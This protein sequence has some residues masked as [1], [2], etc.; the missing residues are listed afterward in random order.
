MRRISAAILFG[1]LIGGPGV[2]AYAQNNLNSAHLRRAVSILDSTKEQDGLVGAVRRVRTES[3]KLELK[4]GRSVEGPLELVELTTYGI[5]GN[6]IE[7]TSY[8]IN[9]SMLGKE[10][11]KYD[12]K[13][14]I[15]ETTLRDERGTILS[16]EA[17]DYEFD[18]IGNWTKMTTSLIVFQ[19]GK[20]NH[21]PIEV[22]YRTL[23]YYFD[24]S[25]AKIIDAPTQA[26]AKLN[27]DLPTSSSASLMDTVKSNGDPAIS[28]RPG[29]VSLAVVE[30]PP[31]LVKK[32]KP[33]EPQP[34]TTPAVSTE[35][36]PVTSKV[37]EVTTESKP[38]GKSPSAF[39]FYRVGRER[40]DAG[41]L[42]AAV[43]AYL[44]SVKI[45]PASAEVHLSL[46]LTYMRLEKDKEALKSF[47]EAVKLNPDLAEA[48]YGLG[49]ASFRLSRFRDASDAFKKAT[50][51]EP[52][53]AKAHYGLALTYQEL[54]EQSLLVQELRTL[55]TLDRNLAKKLTQAFPQMTSCRFS[56]C[57]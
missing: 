38:P 49:I 26:A 9:G 42:K 27:T 48:Q 13:G 25:V 1:T 41:D 31:A 3:A 19:N 56:Q 55:E 40:F 47:K 44:E 52:N 23:T 15:I 12:E 46:G 8:P 45:E 10:E 29:L 5:K 39:E 34:A 7:N 35:N 17:Y 54:G 22:T 57:R 28:S 11:Y 4:D 43:S 53:M 51:L 33:L 14:N 36:R 20:V 16:K 30:D 21:E 6:R 18:K 24:D 50:K 32:S 2:C 37:A